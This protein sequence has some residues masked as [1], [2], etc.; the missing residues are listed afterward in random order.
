[1]SANPI[2]STYTTVARRLPPVTRGL[3]LLGALPAFL[4]RPFEFLLDARARYGDIY[5]LDLGV[6]KPIV[7]NHPRHIQHVFV[8]N[9]KNYYKGGGLWEG[10]RAVSGNGLVVSEGDFWLRQRR[11]L[12]PHFQRKRLAAITDSMVAAAGESLDNWTAAA[13]TR[14]PFDV[15]PAFAQVTMDVICRALF[16]QELSRADLDAASEHATFIFDYLIA[17]VLT[18]ELPRWLPIPGARRLRRAVEELDTIV[19]RII[20]QE[21]AAATPTNSLLG[22]LVEM[23]DE[24]TG[25]GMTDRQLRDEIITFFLAGYETTA[26]TLAWLVHILIQQPDVLGNVEAEVALVLGERAPAFE[27]LMMMPY[28]RAVIQETLRLYPAGFNV[29]RTAAADDEIDGYAIPAGATVVALIYGVHH[30]PG[31]WDDPE[32][33][34][35]ARFLGA[36]PADRHKQAWIPFGAG[37]R[38]CIGRDLSLMETQIILPMLLQRYA[39]APV[40]GRPVQLKLASTLVPKG[41]HV[42]LSKRIKQES[43]M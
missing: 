14:R 36:A 37:Q 7:L 13:D 2:D 15:L 41:A 4:H 18:A 23:V 22:M 3:P 28:T 5:R 17:T 32:R 34:D 11:L 39:L 31:V 1:M 12:Q 29:P 33:F 20:A 38:Q 24:D 8:D 16:G 9:A 21:R 27:D 10:V 42:Y 25:T 6:T 35:P 19:F 26:A 43:A 40:P 30:N